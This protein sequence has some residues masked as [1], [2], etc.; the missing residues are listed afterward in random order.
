MLQAG[1]AAP[2]Q[3]SLPARPKTSVLNLD[4]MSFVQARLLALAL[5]VCL[6]NPVPLKASTLESEGSN[7]IRGQARKEGPEA[8]LGMHTFVATCNSSWL[9]LKLTSVYKKV[10][11]L[12]AG[13]QTGALEGTA[14]P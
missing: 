3:A 9:Q 10:V 1:T 5:A 13:A 6:P 12:Q 11:I 8:R 4:W 7:P 14:C 2:L